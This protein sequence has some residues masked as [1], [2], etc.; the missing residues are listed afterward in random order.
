MMTVGIWFIWAALVWI[1]LGV[2]YGVTK[3][4]RDGNDEPS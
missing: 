4:L 3:E 2:W 1:G